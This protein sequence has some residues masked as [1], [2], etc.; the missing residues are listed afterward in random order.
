MNE[1]SQ[2]GSCCKELAIAIDRKIDPTARAYYLARGCVIKR[3]V[4]FAQYPCPSLI[5][6]DIAGGIYRCGIHETRPQ[7]CRDYDGRAISHGRRYLV[8]DGCTMKRTGKK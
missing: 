6:P 8:P 1:C 7:M 2:C 5:Y 3:G 4:V